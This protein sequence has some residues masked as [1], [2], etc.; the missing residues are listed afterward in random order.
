MAAGCN[1][2]MAKP[3]AIDVPGCLAIAEL[4]KKA[5]TRKKAFLVDFQIRTNPAWVECIRRIRQGNLGKLAMICSYYLSEG[6]P[7]PP[8]TESVESRLR[9][10]VWCNDVGLGGAHLVNASIH[11]IDGALWVA[12]DTQPVSAWGSADLSE[13]SAWRQCRHQLGHN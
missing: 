4:A 6:F 12:G 13:G 8:K 2:Y 9:H 10:L 11:A 1:V 5:S 3:V 7:D